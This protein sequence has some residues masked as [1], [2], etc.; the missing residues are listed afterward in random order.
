MPGHNNPEDDKGPTDAGRTSRMHPHR[1]PPERR[2][3]TVSHRR[4]RENSLPIGQAQKR[5]GDEHLRSLIENNPVKHQGKGTLA[6]LKILVEA[7][8][9]STQNYIGI[10]CKRFRTV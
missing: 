5:L 8:P 3:A 7:E 6:S 2:A 4:K 1:S 10:F 9:R